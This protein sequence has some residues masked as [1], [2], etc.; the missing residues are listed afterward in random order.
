MNYDIQLEEIFWKFWYGKIV[1]IHLFSEKYIKQKIK[2]ELREY[3]MV[4]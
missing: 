1:H 2:F 4:I 3:K